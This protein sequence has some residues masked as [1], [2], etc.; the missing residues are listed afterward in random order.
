MGGHTRRKDG[1][2]PNQLRPGGLQF[3]KLGIRRRGIECGPTRRDHEEE[4]G[5][6]AA[7]HQGSARQGERVRGRDA[8]PGEEVFGRRSPVGN[9]SGKDK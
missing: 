8:Q 7:G 4:G 2:V 5:V 1:L 6:P 9:V 3:S